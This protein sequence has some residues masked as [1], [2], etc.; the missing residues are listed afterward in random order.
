MCNRTNKIIIKH[1]IKL[2]LFD[3]LTCICWL[4]QQRSFKG[5]R[6]NNLTS[7][8]MPAALNLCSAHS[9]ALRS[10]ISI[11]KMTFPDL[12]C[13]SYVKKIFPTEASGFSNEPQ[14]LTLQ[15]FAILRLEHEFQN[16]SWRTNICMKLWWCCTK[17][18]S[19][20]GIEN[21]P[22]NNICLWIEIFPEVQE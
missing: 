20:P 22:S 18:K 12:L 13:F 9:S 5:H 19:H 11:F 16:L 6:I 10:Q 4:V 15:R 7:S 14:H 21:N 2:F 17:P 1:K 8:C 3:S